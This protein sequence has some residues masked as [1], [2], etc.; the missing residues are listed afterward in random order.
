MGKKT[1]KYR[2]EIKLPNN[3]FFHHIPRLVNCSSHDFDLVN[4]EFPIPSS[5]MVMTKKL[6]KNNHVMHTLRIGKSK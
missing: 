1:L 2:N 6:I 3:D 4:F 5:K